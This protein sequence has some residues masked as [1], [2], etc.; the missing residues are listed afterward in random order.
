MGKANEDVMPLL[1]SRDSE[2]QAI[3]AR[4]VPCKGSGSEYAVTS[5]AEWIKWLGYRRIVHRSD[6]EKSIKSVK[7]ETE[8][9]LTEVEF[10]PEEPPG[11]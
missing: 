9:A 10:V 5:G 7:D 3:L 11:W 1:V 4:F 8:R 2:S 6:Q